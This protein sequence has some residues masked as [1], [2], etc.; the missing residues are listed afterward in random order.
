LAQRTLIA[1][2]VMCL[3]AMLTP[4]VGASAAEPWWTPLGL[5]GVAIDAVSAAGK[6]VLVRTGSG[7]T[8]LSD[9][10][11][12][13]YAPVSGNPPI[14]PPA[15]LQSGA[16]AWA[17]DASGRVL[18]AKGSGALTL[19]PASPQLGASAHLI[20]APAAFPGIVVAVAVD[21]VVWRRGQDGDW[22]RALLLLPAGFPHG[23]PRI[24]DAAAFTQPLSGTV[25]LGTDG[26][27]VLS[28]TDGGDDWIRAGPGLPDSVLAL[29][30]DSTT[31]AVYAGTSDG[32]WVHHLRALPAPPA[33]HDAAL[34]WR[35]VGIGLV[36]LLSA[37]AGAALLLLA[38]PRMR[39]A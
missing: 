1:G 30:T 33:Y 10:G 24:T 32:L 31:H 11:G 17:I 27:S 4:A 37:L 35:W 8:M 39:P 18:H 28:S 21:G 13:T 38:L 14:R 25:Y 2:G 22:Q 9:D 36:S 29:T 12:M 7:T 15:I 6:T 20:A 26:Y 16:D 3:A 19:D 23:V 5:R 34:V